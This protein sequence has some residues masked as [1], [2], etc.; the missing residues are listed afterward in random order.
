MAVS[1][2][3]FNELAGVTSALGAS[4]RFAGV[5]ADATLPVAA[6]LKLVGD[7]ANNSVSPDAVDALRKAFEQYDPTVP[8]AEHLLRVTALAAF[9]AAAGAGRIQRVESDLLGVAS[10][11]EGNRELR[12][13]LTNPGATD[14]VKQQLVAELLRGKID[15]IGVRLVNVLIAL[16]HGRDIVDRVKW[17][18]SLAATHQGHVIA[19]VRSAL[20]LD[21]AYRQKVTTALTQAVGKV[22][23]P[24][25]VV[26]PSIVGS[27]VVRI[28][29]EVWD[30][31]IRRHLDQARDALTG[32]AS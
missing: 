29:D 12:F 13:A 1:E 5:L 8:L 16:D 6:K 31:S 9:D 7:V 28:G 25:F 14:D 20:P 2:Q 32:S 17:L 3:T 22:V 24:R 4:P 26:D 19:D 21:D 15:A 23:E 10:L 30:G 11:I 27:L 18:A